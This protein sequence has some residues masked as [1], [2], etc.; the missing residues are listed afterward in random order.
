MAVYQVEVYRLQ[1]L[2]DIVSETV[3]VYQVRAEGH[4]PG[5]VHRRRGEN[6]GDRLHIYRR[7]DGG[8]DPEREEY[9][10]IWIHGSGC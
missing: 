1:L 8:R 10:E 6:L 5:C 4:P 3:A 7:Q 9:G 2:R